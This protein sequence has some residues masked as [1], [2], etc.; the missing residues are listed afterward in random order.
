MVH[1]SSR[2]HNLF[3]LGAEGGQDHSGA[4]LHNLGEILHH[5]GRF[6]QFSSHSA[7]CKGRFALFRGYFAPFTVHFAQVWGLLKDEV[8]RDPCSSV[9]TN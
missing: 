7:L 5:V 6:A 2:Q 3:W 1:E 9:H 4:I 8:T